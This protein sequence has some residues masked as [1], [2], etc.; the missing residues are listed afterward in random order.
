MSETAPRVA[1]KATNAT[2]VERNFRAIVI[3]EGSNFEMGGRA[4]VPLWSLS[5]GAG[6]N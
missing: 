6:G 1:V 5:T 4:A 3:F 2:E